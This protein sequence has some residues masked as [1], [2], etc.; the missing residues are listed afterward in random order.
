MLTPLPLPPGN[1]VQ[2]ALQRL[3][4]RRAIAQRTRQ[5]QRR[6]PLSEAIGAH[7]RACGP[8]EHQSRSEKSSEAPGAGRQKDKSKSLVELRSLPHPSSFRGL[9]SRAACIALGV[10][11]VMAASFMGGNG[12]VSSKSGAYSG[13]GRTPTVEAPAPIEVMASAYEPP[14]TT[15]AESTTSTTESTTTIPE[16][17]TTQ[18]NTTLPP[19]TT[20]APTTTTI[21]PTTTT[22]PKP[23]DSGVIGDDVWA[24]LAAC[25]SGN[26]N[27]TAGPY[28]GYFQFSPATWRSLGGTGLPSDHSYEAQKA[29]AIKLQ[30]RSGWGQWP[31]CSA[32]IGV[33]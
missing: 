4:V 33:R 22:K 18:S 12:V 5:V 7:P 20:K 26:R 24:K 13:L 14:L 21:P 8:L 9:L 16:T 28:Y 29:M 25:E 6:H 19:T 27:Y 2:Q 32:K 10:G 1:E 23:A 11:V 31:A 17:T 3:R 15:A 30:A